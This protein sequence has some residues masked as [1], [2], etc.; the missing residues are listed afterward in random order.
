MSITNFQYSDVG[1]RTLLRTD[2]FFAAQGAWYFLTREGAS[3]G[4]FNDK[5]EARRGLGY[6]IEFMALAKPKLVSR[7]CAY[8]TV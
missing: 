4:P 3:I 7:L 1:Q 5:R 6:F 8:L 2:R